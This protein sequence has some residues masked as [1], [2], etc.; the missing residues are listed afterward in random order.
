MR[1]N[2]SSA[3]SRPAFWGCCRP[4][5]PD[6]LHISPGRAGTPALPPCPHT[7]IAR[8][9]GAAQYVSAQRSRRYRLI[10]RSRISPG[11]AADRHRCP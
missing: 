7:K 6:E 1:E 8:I 9:R 10:P 4:S 11:S 5:F 3:A 2:Y